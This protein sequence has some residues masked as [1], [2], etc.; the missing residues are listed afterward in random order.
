MRQLLGAVLL[1]AGR[2]AEAEVVYWEDLRRNP[3]NG[4]SLHGVWQALLA[5][6]DK[7]NAALVEKRFRRAWAD[8][9]V[10]LTSSRF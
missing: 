1:K 9:D 7:V 8:A 3:E 2:A 4:W 6:G 5:Q 10:T